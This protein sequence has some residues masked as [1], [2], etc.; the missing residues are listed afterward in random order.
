MLIRDERTGDKD[1]I[2]EIIRCA[3]ANQTHSD[4]SEQQIVNSLRDCG[5]L[6][7]SLVAEG[8]GKLAAH[9]AFSPVRIDGALQGWYGLAPVAVRPEL[10]RQ[11]IGLA[12]IN[13]GLDRL[14]KLGANGCVL[15]GEPEYYR[16]FGFRADPRLRL[17]GVPPEFFLVLPFQDAVPDGRVDYHPAFSEVAG[18]QEDHGGQ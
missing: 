5:A 18:V 3:F 12:L 6:T 10:Q 4:P 1:E 9:L 2:E 16:R 8:D 11:G 7:L 15:V 14:R 13:A 17:D